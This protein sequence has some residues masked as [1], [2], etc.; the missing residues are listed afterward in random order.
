MPKT[1]A[2]VL[3]AFNEAD[4][5]KKPFANIKDGI[6]EFRRL[7]DNSFKLFPIDDGSTDGTY[8][9]M[10]RCCA[11]YELP[12]IPYRNEKN[13]G[14]A[15]TVH[16]AYIRILSQFNPDYFLK[17]D[18]DADFNQQTVFER[19]MPFV[20]NGADA[21]AGIRWREISRAE[22]SHEV[23]RR[24]DMLR[25]LKEEFGLTEFDPP[26]AGSQ[27]YSRKAMATL[28]DQP[29]IRNYNRRWGFDVAMPLLA[30]KLGF[31]APV[32]K[33]ENGSYDPKRRPKEKVDAQY[34]AYVEI[35]GQLTGK[36]PAELSTLYAIPPSAP[37]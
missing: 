17:T 15:R 19:L 12:A 27:L 37:E 3:P 9:V 33:I 29:M 13:L 16:D 34:D 21:V 31:G 10:V 18:L 24:E 36:K 8:D 6:D 2:V 5:L 22:N 26:S 11:D 4:G 20:V 30:R 35:V 7:Y 25:I 28:L 14:I 23:D 32:V 1:V